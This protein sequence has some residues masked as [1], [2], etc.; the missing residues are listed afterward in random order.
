MQKW[1]R[2]ICRKEINN[3]STWCL[4]KGTTKT[5]PCQFW[6]YFLKHPGG[7]EHQGDRSLILKPPG[8]RQSL[9]SSLSITI[10]FCVVRSKYWTL[11]L[12]F[13]NPDLSQVFWL[14]SWELCLIW[15]CS[16]LF[17]QSP[18]TA[19]NLEPPHTRPSYLPVRGSQCSSVLSRNLASIRT[20]QFS[21]T[22]G[23]P[24]RKHRF[25]ANSE[26][27]WQI[28]RSFFFPYLTK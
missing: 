24:N 22:L 14:I 1:S 20:G 13:A 19:G 5:F 3:A 27:W 6:K 21:Y 26:T 25:F 12:Y 9:F 2:G 10:F 23:N 18:A 11:G 8:R 4:S 16:P 28:W 15:E 17:S 7:E